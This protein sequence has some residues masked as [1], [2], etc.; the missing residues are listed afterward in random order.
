MAKFSIEFTPFEGY[1]TS[2]FAA[3]VEAIEKAK[4]FA[5]TLPTI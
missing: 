3:R 4:Q 1:K 5:G 2:G